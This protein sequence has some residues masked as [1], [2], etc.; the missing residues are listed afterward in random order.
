MD[1]L[2]VQVAS[3][4]RRRLRLERRIKRSYGK[5]ERRFTHYL[6]LAL[7]AKLYVQLTASGSRKQ[8]VEMA[9][10]L[11]MTVAQ[12]RDTIHHARR[13]G[14]LSSTR[15][16]GASGGELTPKAMEMLRY[17]TDTKAGI[18]ALLRGHKMN[19]RK[20]KKSPADYT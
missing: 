5:L 11:G 16:Q 10:R 18:E 13:E 4:N 19:V 9:G 8:N 7:I 20:R 14:L 12:I 15:K 3:C 1:E 2:C 6:Q 17:E